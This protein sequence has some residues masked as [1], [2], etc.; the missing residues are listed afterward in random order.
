MNN[1]MSFM[2]ILYEAIKLT[3]TILWQLIKFI[4]HY[5]PLALVTI[6]KTKR[7]ITDAVVSEYQDIQKRKREEELN[8][9][10]RA[11]RERI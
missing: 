11:L 2:R 5:T 4:V 9:K 7:E 10:I 3:F 8:A 1:D 6:A